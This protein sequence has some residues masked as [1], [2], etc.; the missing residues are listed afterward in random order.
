MNNMTLPRRLLVYVVA[1]ENG[2]APNVTGD[3]CSLTVCKPQV[4]LAATPGEDWV[5]GMSTTKHGKDRLIYAMQVA[6][7]LGYDAFFTDPRFAAKKPTP[8]NPWGDNFFCATAEGLALSTPVAA[9]AGKPDAL[10]RDLKAPYAVIGAPYWYFG[11]NAPTLPKHLRA[12]RIVQGNRRGH[13]VITDP[14]VIRA[15]C[16]WLTKAY[17]AGTHGTPRDL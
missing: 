11:A 8:Q 4:R 14:K 5:I 6:E 17:P 2:L 16:T 1:S 3:Q 15:F 13:R 9:H 10:K 12:T 7:K